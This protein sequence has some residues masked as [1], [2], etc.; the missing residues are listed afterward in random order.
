MIEK[1]VYIDGERITEVR[2]EGGKLLYRK[3]PEGYEM[4][5]PRTKQL[6]VVRYDQMLFDCLKC[7][8]DNQSDEY[9]KA[10]TEE[11]RSTLNL[12]Q[13]L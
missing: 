1:T 12:S 6:C 5:C 9:L 13:S 7:F 10:K 3:T 2:S 4:K 8:S 11:I